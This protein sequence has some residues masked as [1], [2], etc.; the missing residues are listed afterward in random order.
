[1]A[2]RAFRVHGPLVLI[3][4]LFFF[5]LNFSQQVP[6][7]IPVLIGAFAG[8]WFA[9]RSTLFIF[10]GLIPLINGLCVTLSPVYIFHNV[11]FSCLYLPWFIKNVLLHKQH[12]TPQSPPCFL[13]DLL[14]TIILFSLAFYLACFPA[15]LILPAL[16]SPASFEQIHPLYAVNAAIILLQGLFFF[17]L[18]GIE[19]RGKNIVPGLTAVVWALALSV[20]F[21]SGFQLLFD[22][23]PW[24]MVKLFGRRGLFSPFDDI[25]SYGSIIVVLFSVFLFLFLG[26][27]GKRRAMC[28]L[29]SLLLFLCAFF[30]LS[31]ITILTSLAIL[32]FACG[33]YLSRK[34]ITWGLVLLV[35]AAVLLLAYREK[36]PAYSF[37]VANYSVKK[38]VS[39]SSLDMRFHRW[40][41]SLNMIGSAPLAGH[42]IGTYYRLYPDFS[43]MPSAP[44]DSR[45]I[46]YHGS[47]NAHNYYIQLAA[48]LGVPAMLIFMLLLFYV[49]RSAYSPVAAAA[50]PQLFRAGLVA[51]ISGYLITCLTSHPLLLPVQQFLFWFTVA[52]AWLLCAPQEKAGSRIFSRGLKYFLLVLIA[53]I[54]AGY[55]QYWFR[56]RHVGSYEYGLYPYQ[57]QAQGT[58]RWTM[59][60]AGIRMVARS[61]LIKFT[62][63]TN[64]DTIA[65]N[66]VSLQLF[67]DD[68]LLDELHIIEP[69]LLPLTYF[70]PGIT[71][72]EILLRISA[73]TTYNPYRLGISTDNRDLG[74][75]LAPIEFLQSLPTDGIG[76]Y[77]KELWHDVKPSGWPSDKPLEFRWMSRQATLPV[78]EAARGKKLSLF[79]SAQHPDI[80][81]APVQVT[82]QGNGPALQ[83]L[84]LSDAAWKKIE[85]TPEQTMSVTALTIRISRV[86][87][88]R[89]D[90]GSRDIRDLGLMVAVAD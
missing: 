52:A 65:R 77:Q 40:M 38:M 1:M 71:N 30:S 10:A 14:S 90:T 62:I 53:G 11:L 27:T 83:E 85:L 7:L 19:G 54:T 6:L 84:M 89:L 67:I 12:L 21:F 5:C 76:F 42:G 28:G 34:M 25:N 29:V 86:W 31:R 45:S 26:S 36:L 66:S 43:S 88:P 73:N 80:K 3:S 79:L 63:L 64:R 81:T 22:V 46:F 32:L 9:P 56:P 68:M 33:R 48:D 24:K 60:E 23:P 78:A 4:S 61:D 37:P 39:S 13:A 70:V 50:Y 20:L 75:A 16:W 15:E 41:I 8:A 51:G 44:E 47:E 82:I 69:G 74:V 18:L 35:L 55:M 2:L 58:F 72:R 59:K 49:Y 17:R 87:N 57:Q